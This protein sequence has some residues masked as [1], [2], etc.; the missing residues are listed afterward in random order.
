MTATP[1]TDHLIDLCARGVVPVKDWRNRDTPDA[2]AKLAV[3]GALL[4]AGCEWRL[5]TDPESTL[6]TWWIEIKHPTFGTFD[7]GEEEDHELFYI[8]TEGRLERVAGKD[9]Y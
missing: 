4:K 7:W 8:P 9:W 5:S 1:H 6:E 2:Q 3:A